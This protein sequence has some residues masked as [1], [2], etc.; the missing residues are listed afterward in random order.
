MAFNWTPHQKAA[1]SPTDKLTVLSAAAGSGKT[2]VLVERA[3]GLLLDDTKPVSAD[4]ML[5]VTFSNASAAE[6]K[7]RI[8]KGINEKIIENPKNT[9]IKMQKVA[10][11]RA[12]ISTI[13]SFC[14]KLVRENFQSLDISPDFTI[15]DNAQGNALH[16]DAINT[17]MSYGYTIPDFKELVSFYG[18]SSSDQ[19]IKDFLRQ[20]N[21][22]FSALPNPIK[23]AKK[24]AREYN[25]NL[26]LTNSKSYA[27]ILNTIQLYSNYLMYLSNRMDEINQN[28][29]FSG[30]DDGI[31]QIRNFA[32]SIYSAA[33]SKNII[34]LRQITLV[35]IPSLGRVRGKCSESE[36]VQS[37]Y[38]R[39]KSKVNEISKL[40]SYLNQTDYET[41][42]KLTERYVN[43]LFDVFIYYQNVLM[44]TKKKKKLFEFYDFEHFALKLLQNEDGTPTNLCLALRDHY[45]YIMEDEFQDTSFVQ[46]AIF[47]MIA[48]EGESNL[49]VVGD[50]KQSIYGFRKASPEIFLSKR[51][52]GIDDNTKGNTIFLPDNFRSSYN[53][54]QGVNYIF[55]SL[56][57]KI[58]GGIDYDDSEALVPKNEQDNSIGI[59]VKLWDENEAENIAQ[60]I[61]QMIKKGYKINDKGTMRPVKSGDF[62]ILLRNR[63]SFSEYKSEL[64]KL[65][66]TAFVKDDEL[67]LNKPEVQSVINL[68]RIIANPLQEVYLTATMFGDIFGFSL[69]EILKI[70]AVD[71]SINLYKA[72]AISKDT[73]AQNMLSILKDI[74]Y[75]SCVYSADKLIDYICK[76]TGYYQR[77]SFSE[78]GRIK[79]ENIRW[80]IDFAHNWAKTHQS[81]LSA[82]LRWID[83]YLESGSSSNTE[84][85]KTP[86]AISIMTMHTS[87][88]LEFPICIVASLT[89]MFNKQDTKKRLLLDTD[90]GI[91]MYANKKF[92]YNNST[93][94][95]QAIKNKNAINAVS[96][97][98]RLLYVAF[99]RSKNLLILSGQIERYF[100][101]S[102]ISDIVACT[103]GK[104]H[105]VQIQD[106]STPMHWVLAAF[107]HHPKIA[108][109]YSF[110]KEDKN[111]P[112]GINIELHRKIE[113]SETQTY[114][115]NSHEQIIVD[116]DK[117]KSN[118]S[119]IYPNIARTSLP[120]KLSV[121]EIAKSSKITLANPDFINEGKAS[122]SEKG[123]AMHKFAQHADILL[124]RANMENELQRLENIGLIQRSLLD[125]NAL[126]KFIFSDLATKIINSE[127]VYTEKDF[128]VPYNAAKILDNASYFNDEILIQG[129]MDCVLQNGNEI[130]IIDYKT[131]K[132]NS[133]ETLKSRYEKQLEL[134][135][136]GAKY[137]FKTENVKCILYS[138]NLN[139]W[140]EF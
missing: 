87:K 75:V 73:K 14:I 118:L 77:I 113:T 31:E 12:D 61:S 30:Y 125:E 131:D 44:E 92:G 72:L 2:T 20:M 38:K 69:D 104:P 84:V 29:D 71:K 122:A 67:I 136:H 96:E 41:D 49:Y 26:I 101:D 22:F 9:Y 100:T 121:S 24:M 23:T 40:I 70:R 68:L 135:R 36:A 79:R 127:N 112:Y 133:I 33:K 78:D 7:N 111:I 56:M 110:S 58:R 89:T 74:S 117:V 32:T 123:T 103:G 94:N 62:C 99:T 128:L 53:V 11:Q 82:F 134:Y 15:C 59:E 140:V 27:Q 8:E 107:C 93:I 63:S 10:L 86:D 13:H 102:T 83:M 51:Q 64:E 19:K 57:S 108:D 91:G 97:E 28:S 95:V 81:D 132:V 55:S 39:F 37:V 65:G 115:E 85:Q 66:Y 90:L 6:F 129:I 139:E 4:K 60:T 48:K 126:E 47:T 18:K 116:I 17:A 1:L 119:F 3:I 109:L 25:E 16:D 138:F 54:I 50:L 35:N 98:M 88:G 34:A 43:V 105:P 45:E 137:L 120:I 130:T 52:V 46:D 5:I 42:I 80:F 124:A 21:Y 76:T 114:S 106:F